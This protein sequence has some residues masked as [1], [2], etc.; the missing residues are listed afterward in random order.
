MQG[1]SSNINYLAPM[2]TTTKETLL[3]TD[4]TGTSREK[5]TSQ[6]NT[7]AETLNLKHMCNN[8]KETASIINDMFQSDPNLDYISSH[9]KDAVK[10]DK[11]SKRQLLIE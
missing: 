10:I 9:N 6:T 3:V 4:I 8:D 5:E 11:E 2:L 7:E 1:Q